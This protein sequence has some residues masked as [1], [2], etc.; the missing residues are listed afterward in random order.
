MVPVDYNLFTRI[1]LL[2]LGATALS[3]AIP[4]EGALWFN[5]IRETLS[6]LDKVVKSLYAVLFSGI[7]LSCMALATLGSI[8]LWVERYALF[9]GL[10]V[11]GIM[12][13]FAITSHETYGTD[14][15]AA[16]N[17]AAELL[18]K[19]RNPYNDFVLMDAYDRYRIP[20]Q[21]VTKFVD[22]SVKVDYMYPG[23][24]F[25]SLLPFVALGLPDARPVYALCLFAMAVLAYYIAVPSSKLLALGLFDVLVQN[26]LLSVAG[27]TTEPL[28]VLPV[29]LAW[30]ARDRAVLPALFLG[31]AISIKQLAWFFA[32][33]FLLLTYHQHGRQK[34]L[35]AI[36]LA[37]GVFALLNGPFILLSPER[38]V[39]AVLSPIRDPYPALGMG[40]A[41]LGVQLFPDVPRT[42]YSIMSIA[43]MG[44][45][46]VF[47]AL[48]GGRYPQLALILPWLPLWFGWRSFSTYFLYLPIMLLVALVAGV[49]PQRT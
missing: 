9:V 42:F 37:G 2:L 7:G 24:S 29:M 46:L 35:V 16:P 20:P 17:Y 8:A 40:A 45:C 34:T 32:P 12:L 49:R 5:Y 22:G 15:G 44:L 1:G 23:G 38:W 11:F 43:A 10:F 48:R 39:T 27:G 6:P 4:V 33:F 3:L 26:N 21:K 14:A 36:A 18:I 47:F 30:L 31:Y 25:I 19:G 41:M 13:S 28:W